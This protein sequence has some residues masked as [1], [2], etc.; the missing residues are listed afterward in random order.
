[1]SL[2]T[3]VPFLDASLRHKDTPILGPRNVPVAKQLDGG[4]MAREKGRVSHGGWSDRLAE[5]TLSSP[6][7]SVAGAGHGTRRRPNLCAICGGEVG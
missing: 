6:A 2:P 1:M 7:P 3:C 4:V 5:S